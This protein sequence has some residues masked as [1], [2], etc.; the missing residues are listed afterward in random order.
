VKDKNVLMV[1][2]LV[3][4]GGSITQAAEA[5]RGM[6]AKDIYACCSHGVLSGNAIEKIEKSPIC[7]FVTTDTIP[8]RPEMKGKKFKVLS[9]CN[10]IGE[11]IR[12]IFNEESISSLF[13]NQR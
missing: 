12:R 8:M 11:S 13:V 10:I 1:D 6:G 2:D 9:A 3:D 5:V 4:T 7:E